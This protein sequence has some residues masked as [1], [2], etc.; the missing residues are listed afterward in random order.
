MPIKRTSY[1]LKNRFAVCRMSR[2][3]RCVG[4]AVPMSSV[5]SAEGKSVLAS[6]SRSCRASAARCG[7]R[8]SDK[9]SSRWKRAARRHRE[10]RRSNRE[11]E[12]AVERRASVVVSGRHARRTPTPAAALP[13]WPVHTYVGYV[14]A[15]DC[16][17]VWFPFSM[18]RAVHANA[19][20]IRWNAL[21]YKRTFV[22]SPIE[23]GM[24]ELNFFPRI[25]ALLALVR[26]LYHIIT[27]FP[28]FSRI[29]DRFR[30]TVR[31]SWPS[32][33]TSSRRSTER[34]WCV[35]AQQFRE[36]NNNNNIRI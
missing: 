3:R 19:R 27:F 32:T 10:A 8:R 29:F 5:R 36:L 15:L 20:K 30:Q 7:Q 16:L 22:I 31:M 18:C 14:R 28:S 24:S 11:W 23:C 2:A 9:E 6:F 34:R 33:A 13:T 1:W 25:P 4:A 17:R 21:A 35:R 12:C 26:L